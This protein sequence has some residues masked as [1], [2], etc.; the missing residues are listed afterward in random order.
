MWKLHFSSLLWYFS[1]TRPVAPS[2]QNDAVCTSYGTCSGRQCASDL[3]GSSRNEKI[4]AHVVRGWVALRRGCFGTRQAACRLQL[5]VQSVQLMV[6]SRQKCSL[7]RLF[8]F[9]RTSKL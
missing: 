2:C 1:C 9:K 3:E 5:G 8:G 6:R 7:K 4:T